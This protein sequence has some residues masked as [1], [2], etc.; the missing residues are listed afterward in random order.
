[1]TGARAFALVAEVPLLLVVVL[2]D[3]SDVPVWAVLTG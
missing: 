1:V 3:H 2:G